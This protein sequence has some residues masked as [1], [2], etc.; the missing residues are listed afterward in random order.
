MKDPVRRDTILTVVGFSLIAAFFVFGIY[1]PGQKAAAEL[2]TEI[3]TLQRSIRD[4]PDRV[5]ELRSLREAIREREDYI[6]GT[7][8]LIPG[9]GNVDRVLAEVS[10]FAQSSHL[11][12]TRLEPLEV[13]KRASYRVLPFRIQFRGRFAG[14]MRLLSGLERHKRLF[15]VE[16]LLLEQPR[17]PTERVIEGEIDFSVYARPAGDADSA[18]NDANRDRRV[19]DRR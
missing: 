16:K 9:R 13:V 2:R 15:A 5:E 8:R 7:E 1:L 12:V 4:V 17:G 14:V 3:A 10:Q 11:T 18:E 19:A 6:R